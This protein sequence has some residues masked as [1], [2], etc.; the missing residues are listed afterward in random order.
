MN[1][2]S[3]LLSA[4]GGAAAVTVL[5]LYTKFRRRHVRTV[6]HPKVP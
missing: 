2:V 5:V 3:I 1:V 4:L 6:I